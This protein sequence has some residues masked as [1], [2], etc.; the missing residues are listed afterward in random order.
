MF[1]KRLLPVLS[2]TAATKQNGERHTMV[3]VCKYLFPGYSLQDTQ[4]ILSLLIVHRHQL[5]RASDRGSF[6]I[7]NHLRRFVSGHRNHLAR[8]PCSPL[9]TT[10]PFLRKV[11]I[12]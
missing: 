4:L 12:F 5:D 6:I 8:L 10:N 1:T 9:S 3:A 7:K 2:L 11:T